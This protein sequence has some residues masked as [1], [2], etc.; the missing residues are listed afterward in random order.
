MGTAKNPSLFTV[1]LLVIPLP[2]SPENEKAT[3]ANLE[4]PSLSSDDTSKQLFLSNAGAVS[5]EFCLALQTK[6]YLGSLGI[7]EFRQ[8][9]LALVCSSEPK[10]M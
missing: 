1:T 6:S 8:I 2:A 10:S 7:S 9:W 3:F 5:A 4:Y